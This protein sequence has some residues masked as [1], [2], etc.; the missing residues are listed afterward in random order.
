MII[1]DFMSPTE[2]FQN[3]LQAV[4]LCVEI[5]FSCM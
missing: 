3:D 2:I 5:I 1:G 4:Y